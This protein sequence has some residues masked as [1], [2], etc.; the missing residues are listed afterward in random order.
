MFKR[1]EG[2]T[3]THID[4]QLQNHKLLVLKSCTDS[5]TQSNCRCKSSKLCRCTTERPSAHSLRRPRTLSSRKDSTNYGRIGG[6]RIGTPGRVGE[7]SPKTRP[8]QIPAR[9]S[10]EFGGKVNLFTPFPKTL[11]LT[12]AKAQT[13]QELHAERILKVEKAGEEGGRRG[14]TMTADH[15]V[16]NTEKESRLRYWHTIWLL[17]GYTIIRAETRLHKVRREVCSESYLQK[18]RE[19]HIESG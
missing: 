11:N 2:E 18:E 4:Q 13:S 9:P 19:A 15:K 7:T 16:L 1:I 5:R 3:I 14:G 8:P 10:F 12:F 17:K 6:K